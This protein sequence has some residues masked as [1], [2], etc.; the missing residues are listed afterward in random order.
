MPN[1]FDVWEGHADLSARNER[2]NGKLV[3]G[4][5]INLGQNIIDRDK[6]VTEELEKTVAS[7]NILEH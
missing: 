1:T 2:G 5:C 7:R 6:E 4:W 3:I